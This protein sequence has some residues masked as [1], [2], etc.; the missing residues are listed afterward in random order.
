MADRVTAAEAAEIL[1]VPQVEVYRLADE[2]Q[3]MAFLEPGDPLVK[4]DLDEVRELAS[5]QQ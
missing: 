4:L 2:R 1:G 5:Q 3:L